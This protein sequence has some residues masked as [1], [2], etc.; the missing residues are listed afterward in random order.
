MFRTAQQITA[1]TYEPLLLYCEA[2]L[3]YLVFCSV[4]SVLQ[5]SLERRFDR[6]S[7]H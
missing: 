1:T 3:Y 4:L 6:Y 7:A 2:A 5:N